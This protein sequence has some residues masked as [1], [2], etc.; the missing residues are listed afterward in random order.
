MRYPFLEKL[1]KSGGAIQKVI[2]FNMVSVN[3]NKT[4]INSKQP[5]FTYQNFVG[6]FVKKKKVASLN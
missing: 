6:C 4:K 3:Y 5:S 2:Q 1:V